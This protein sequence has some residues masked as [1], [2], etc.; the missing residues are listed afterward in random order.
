[1]SEI[2]FLRKQQ[3]GESSDSFITDLYALVEYCEYG[4]L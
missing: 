2:L 1:M 4:A 3:P